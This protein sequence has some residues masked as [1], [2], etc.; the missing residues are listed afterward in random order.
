MGSGNPSS[1]S[2][3]HPTTSTATTTAT[4]PASDHLAAST[5]TSASTNFSFRSGDNLLRVKR[6]IY[7]VGLLATLLAIGCTVVVMKKGNVK[8]LEEDSHN[9]TGTNKAVTTDIQLRP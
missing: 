4:R 8:I 9:A 2:C 5:S 7:L 6:H 1:T 3:N